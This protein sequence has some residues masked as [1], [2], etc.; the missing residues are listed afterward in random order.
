MRWASAGDDRQAW[1]LG[2]LGR[3]YR[4]DWAD[5]DRCDWAANDRAVG[6]QAGRLF[7]AYRLPAAVAALDSELWIIT[8]DLDHPGTVMTAPAENARPANTLT[9]TST[10]GGFRS[11]TITRSVHGRVP[12][13]GV[14]P[15]AESCVGGRSPM[16]GRGLRVTAVAVVVDEPGDG[17]GRP[18]WWAS[19]GGRVGPFGGGQVAPIAQP[20]LVKVRPRVAR[21]VQLTAA[22]RVTASVVTRCRPRVRARR[23]PQA[24]RTKW[25]ILRSTPGRMWR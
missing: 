21:R 7:S 19:I 24:A 6:L 16:K 17:G 14:L 11:Q 3:H 1:V 22:A 18:A 10:E 8:D 13:V 15:I 2:C 12:L 25:A 4:R 5:V 20:A 23:P 9:P